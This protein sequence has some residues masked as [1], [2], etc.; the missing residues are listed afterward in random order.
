MIT[1]KKAHKKY[2]KVY[3]KYVRKRIKNA[4]RAKDKSTILDIT[5]PDEII[6]ELKEK[7]GYTVDKG[8]HEFFTGGDSYEISG[9]RND[10]QA[11][12]T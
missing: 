4:I 1:A 11:E 10:E 12:Q 6:Q 2:M 9:W 8:K 5:T 3:R 7:Y